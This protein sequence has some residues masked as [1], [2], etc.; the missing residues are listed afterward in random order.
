MVSAV[1]IGVVIGARRT[2]GTALHPGFAGGL[3]AK[4]HLLGLEG[5]KSSFD[6]ARGQAGRE[7]N[8]SRWLMHG[9]CMRD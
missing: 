7:E 6:R 4:E 2:A 9:C 8:Q 5:G 1:V 3:E